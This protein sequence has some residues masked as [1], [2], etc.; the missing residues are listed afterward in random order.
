VT[1]SLPWI[2]LGVFNGAGSLHSSTPIA[3]A[4]AFWEMPI[5]LRYSSSR[6]SPGVMFIRITIDDTG[7]VNGIGQV[8]PFPKGS[9]TIQLGLV[10]AFHL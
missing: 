2:S 1:A 8:E 4:I 5:G 6:I 3:R 10:G 7:F 9:I